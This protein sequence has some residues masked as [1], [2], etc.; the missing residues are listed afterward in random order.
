MTENVL[1]P[2][3]VRQMD[4]TTLALIGIPILAVIALYVAGRRINGQHQTVNH[5][6]GRICAT[7]GN[8]GNQHVCKECNGKDRWTTR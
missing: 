4:I 1:Q 2:A 7:C 8:L 3:L 6:P 5:I